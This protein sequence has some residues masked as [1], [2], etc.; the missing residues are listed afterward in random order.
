[1]RV[2]DVLLCRS[3]TRAMWRRLSNFP[4]GYIRADPGVGAE[5]VW[6]P[7]IAPEYRVDKAEIRNHRK[8]ELQSSEK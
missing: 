6:I 8:G 1:M 7:C 5:K 4:R 2:P 3:T